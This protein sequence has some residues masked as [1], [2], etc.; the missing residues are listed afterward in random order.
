[1]NRRHF[2][3]KTLATAGTVVI[4]VGAEAQRATAGLSPA[5]G[6]T[7]SFGGKFTRS[8]LT[9]DLL[10]VG[11]G[12]AGICAALAAARNGLKVILVQDR[13][14]LGGNASSEVKMHVVGADCSGGRLGTRESGLIEELR[15]EDAAR[16]PQR[17]YSLWDLLLYEKI[18]YNPNITLL[19][20][21][22]CVGCTVEE[23]AGGRRIVSAHVVRIMTEESFEIRARYFADCSGDSRLAFEAG[24][25]YTVGREDKLTYTEEMGQ[26]EADKMTLGSSILITARKYE[27]PMPFIPPPWIHKFDKR[28]FAKRR[29]VEYDYGYWWNE[30]GGQLD[31]I[32]DNDRIRHYLLSTALGIWDY[33][34][35]SGEHP[36]AANYALDWVGAIPGK[37]ESRRLLGDYVLVQDD[38]V[39]G[40]VFPDQVAYGGWPLD[41]HEPS[42]IEAFERAPNRAP[43]LKDLYSIPLRSLYSR[44]IRNLFMA[45]RNISASHIAFS[46]TRVMATCAVMGQAV[47]TA[48][49]YAATQS[50]SRGT[51]MANNELAE[52]AHYKAVQQLLLKDDAFLLGLRNEDPADRARR[53]QVTAS[54]TKSEGGRPD[55]I[56]D[57]YTRRMKRERFGVWADTSPHC[58]M[59]QELPA[60]IQLEWPAE[61]EFREVHLTFDTGF[62]RL[63]TL[64]ASESYARRSHRAPQPETVRDYALFLDDKEIATVTGNYLRKRIHRFDTPLKG[65]RLRL[66]AGAAHGVPEARVFEIRAY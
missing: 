13:S 20:D 51:A 54:S 56:L 50:R 36:G 23:A 45:G 30:W 27:Q 3:Q 4:P 52:P 21:S 59:S 7:P 44:N 11:G 46:S 55:V 1:M 35:N 28:H 18:H 66:V 60:W 48:A 12:M 38:L 15:L 19:L 2:L 63:L 5:P 16:N 22:D 33:I 17:C 49:A 25:D 40:R 47:G 58:W 31:T 8:E 37:R 9:T 24:A 42:G 39:Q 57:G 61:Q 65:R 26:D 34:K 32:K 62:E 53:A 43:A 14:V 64:T 6:A 29:V 41:V 10:V